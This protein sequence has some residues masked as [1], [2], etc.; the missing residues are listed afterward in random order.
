MDERVRFYFV[1]KKLHFRL[2]DPSATIG[3]KIVETLY[4]NGLTSENKRIHTP[5][6]SP[7][8]QF[9]VFVVFYRY[10]E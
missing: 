8:F 2:R 4:S 3:D 1:G 7:P 5:P 10:F 6:H 9:G